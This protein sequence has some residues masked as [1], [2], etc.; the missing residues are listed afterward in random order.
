MASP[1]IL[2]IW[3]KTWSMHTLQQILGQPMDSSMTMKQRYTYIGITKKLTAPLHVAYSAMINIKTRLKTN[4]S[5]NEEEELSLYDYLPSNT[6]TDLPITDP[7]H[8][9]YSE[10]LAE[11]IHN[12]ELSFEQDNGSSNQGTSLSLLDRM[13]MI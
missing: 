7:F 13:N 3:L 4:N 9:E 8:P 2:R 10:D 12:I 11:R 5:P 1:N 6:H